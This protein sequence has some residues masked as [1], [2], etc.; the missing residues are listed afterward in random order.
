WFLDT[1]RRERQ[2]ALADNTTAE[3]AL[4]HL[5]LLDGVQPTHACVLLFGRAPQHF[6]PASEIKCMHFHG[7]EVRK[8]IPSYQVYKGTA[9]DLVDQAVDFAMSSLTRSVGTRARGPRAP[10]EYE[11]PKDAVAEALVNAVAH[12]DYTS[13]ASAQVM[14]F[15]DRL[16][17]WNPGE[18]PP[19]LTPERLLQPHASI[20]RNPLICEPLFLA[21]YIEKAGTGTLDMAAQCRQSDLPE[22]DFEQREGQFVVTLWR[23]WLTPHEL[24]ALGVTERQSHV[25]LAVKSKG[26]LTNAEY[27]KISGVLRK[28][29]ARDLSDLV[30]KGVLKQV[31][32]GR[33]S[34][35]IV[36]RKRAKNRTMG[37]CT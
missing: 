4:T 8:P 14:L 17:V 31:G 23:D 33:G 10:V 37:V 16:E 15:S 3:K 29:A 12:R 26:R 22:P 30:G 32:T 2:Y 21:H 5:N 19:G 11:L 13:N 7:T 18:L 35:Y 1:A 34:H 25:L 27:Q 36:R 9:F 28:T 20:P 24:D 6:L